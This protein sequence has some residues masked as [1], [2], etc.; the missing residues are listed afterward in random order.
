MKIEV[1]AGLITIGIILLC[2]GCASLIIF[3]PEVF[4]ALIMGVI[5]SVMVY[6]L[7]HSVLHDLRRAVDKAER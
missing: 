7:Y 3:I 1:Q 2:I 5:V 6:H 4:A